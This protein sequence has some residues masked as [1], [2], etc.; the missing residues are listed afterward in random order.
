MRLGRLIVEEKEEKKGGEE[1]KKR[2]K[3][4]QEK[5][6]RGRELTT[7]AHHSFSVIVFIHQEARVSCFLVFCFISCK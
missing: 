5:Q 2:R 4:E 6:E 1:K 3:R 7:P